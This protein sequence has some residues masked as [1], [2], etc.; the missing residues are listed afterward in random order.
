MLSRQIAAPAVTVIQ[1]LVFYILIAT[2]KLICETLI[3]KGPRIGHKG[4]ALLRCQL[5]HNYFE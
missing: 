4:L 1:I 2:V 3:E 5:L